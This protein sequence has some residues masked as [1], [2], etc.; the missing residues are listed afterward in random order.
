MKSGKLVLVDLAGSEMVRKTNSSG[1]Q[2]EEAKM[3]NKSLS[4]LG[5]VINA[6][7]DEKSTH[8]PYRDSKLT[9]VLQDSLGGNSKTVL[10]VAVSPS[11]YNAME[12]VSTLRF[13]TR[14]KSIENKVSVNQTRSIEEL[15]NLLMRAEKAIDAQ[16]A[17][18]I[19]LTTQL[20]AA[21]SGGGRAE[22]AGSSMRLEAETAAL[23]KL[24]DS[25]SALT[26]ELD[27]ERQDSLRKDA[28]LKEM[29]NLIR[30]K[31]RLI[32]EAATLL[33]EVQRSNEGLK[34]RAEQI[35]KEKIEAV[36]ELESLKGSVNDQVSKIKFEKMELELTI[37]TLQTE[38]RQLKT[39]IAELSGDIT[40]SIDERQIKQTK[41][42][43]VTSISA[44]EDDESVFRRPGKRGPGDASSLAGLV[45]IVTENGKV[46]TAAAR[47]ELIDEYNTQFA[48]VCLKHGISEDISAELFA[49]LDDFANQY[50]GGFSALEDKFT[51]LNKSQ[52]K[53]IREL[54]DHRARLEKD[55]QSRI[56]N[57]S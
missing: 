48:S 30:E 29:A 19:S 52:N 47:K 5:Q 17:H 8:V 35:L 13:G 27:D 38:N 26:Q 56:Q 40:D 11:S 20:Q 42:N 22:G 16:T 55:L 50:E 53:R 41:K 25:V 14:A 1:Q 39:E 46:M 15:E 23:K 49:I 44:V 43:I 36:G 7:T 10:I 28:E 21:N 33:A 24:E 6:L 31:E 34:D 51:Q 32:Q 2:L 37:G 4:A 45:T 9:R 3:I 57:V 12:T 18:I 54:E